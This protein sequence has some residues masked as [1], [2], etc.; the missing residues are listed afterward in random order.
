MIVEV[1]TQPLMIEIGGRLSFINVTV[2]TGPEPKGLV[3][4]LHDLMSKGAEFQPLAG[5]LAAQGWKVVA[6]D[7]PGRGASVRVPP[8][9]YTVRMGVDVAAAVMQAHQMQRTL[10][11]GSG[12]GAMLA[13][14][15]EN[16]WKPAP[17]RLVLCDLPLIWSF[18]TDLRAQLWAQLGALM[19]PTD[20]AFLEQAAAI[21]R[22]HGAIG[23]DVL[24]AVA[25]RLTGPEGGRSLGVDP[26]IFDILRRT[27]NKNSIAGPMLRVSRAEIILLFGHAMAAQGPEIQSSR[28]APKRRPTLAYAE[29]KT[30]VDWNNP[31][32]A[33]PVL[34][35][36]LG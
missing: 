9:F 20:G 12:W 4:C 8:Q 10:V 36:I 14:A 25:S 28:F 3:L 5:I 18:G 7:F 26:G 17:S 23:A 27:A 15:L 24:A 21:V 22:H 34:G 19:A 31:S 35:A 30:F 6:P 33:L 32:A 1:Y 13:L 2:T 16:T 29:C 11:L